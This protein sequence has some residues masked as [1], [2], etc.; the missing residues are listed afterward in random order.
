MILFAHGLEGS[1]QGSKIRSLRA[2][3]IEV[4]APD[5]Q[6]MALAARVD[7]LTAVSTEFA[8]DR[9]LLVG[10]S[11]GGI[12][13]AIVASR[14]PERF[15]GLLLLAPALGITEP[16][17]VGPLTAPG[18]LPTEV[19]HGEHDAIVPISVSEAYCARSGL[20]LLRADDGHRLA[21]SHAEIVRLARAL[22]A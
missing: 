21:E 11:Y 13:S 22:G 3:G 16:P 1:P 19:L 2:A 7:L 9:P 10:S 8:A 17:V 20:T 18:G 5:F 15:R 4:I 12:T 14:H 6:G